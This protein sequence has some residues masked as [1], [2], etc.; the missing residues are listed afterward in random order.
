MP[1]LPPDDSDDAGA[2]PSDDRADR[3][4][5]TEPTE[6]TERPVGPQQA[7]QPEYSVQFAQPVQAELSGQTPNEPTPKQHDRQPTARRPSQARRWAAAI[8]AL[9]VPVAGG[10]TLHA[11]RGTPAFPAQW[12]P[13]I[14]ELVRWVERDRGLEFKHP[15]YVDYQ[16]ESEFVAGFRQGNPEPD[17]DTTFDEIARAVG[18]AE[19][20]ID[21]ARE[22]E[23]L[24]DVGVLAYYSPESQRIRIRGTDIDVEQRVILVHELTHALQDQHFDLRGMFGDAAKGKIYD[25]RPL[26]EGDASGVEHRYV[27]DLSAAE[28]REYEAGAEA[29]RDD[30]DLDRF[31]TFLLLNFDFPYSIGGA[32]VGTLDADGGRDA[33]DAAFEHL[34]TSDRMVM[35]PLSY[36]DAPPLVSVDTFDSLPP[37][38]LLEP[39]GEWGAFSLYLMLAE[40]IDPAEALFA[41]LGW[42]D[43]NY[44]VIESRGRT[45]VE[46]A[47][48][49][50]NG[51][52]TN[53]LE[54]VLERWR[55]AL[56]HRDLIRVTRS[57]EQVDVLACDPGSGSRGAVTDQVEDAY[58]LLAVRLGIIQAIVSGPDIDL[59]EATC[60]A[61]RLIDDQ[62]IGELLDDEVSAEFRVARAIE[63]CS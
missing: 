55:R 39:G 1:N 47:V 34:P 13:E 35:D 14:E 52:T 58:G 63:D 61:D 44:R 9:G 42:G 59:D 23:A 32:F 21:L 20:N 26:V 3:A 2:P 56:P 57:G 22:A 53:A 36:T 24:Y 48:R 30:A 27:S 16:S 38:E 60:V 41:T 17:E 15:V 11:T 7:P 45:C 46:L 4:D 6:R 51:A 12:D 28:R 31:P 43:D 29:A 19:G 5:R 54:S 18:L 62:D 25:P 37:D 40:Q 33:V 8:L 49:G 10:V 50:E